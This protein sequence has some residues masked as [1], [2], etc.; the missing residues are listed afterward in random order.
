MVNACLPAG[1]VLIGP[2][3]RYKDELKELPDLKFAARE[4][5]FSI[6]VYCFWIE[7]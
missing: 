1:R 5:E 2:R 3:F 4:Q 6:G 7:M